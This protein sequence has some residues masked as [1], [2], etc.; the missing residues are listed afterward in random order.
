[1]VH[2]AMALH[3]STQGVF[4][5]PRS[6]KQIRRSTTAYLALV[7]R[8]MPKEVSSSTRTFPCL[9]KERRLLG[10]M[11]CSRSKQHQDVPVK[12]GLCHSV[13]IRGQG[14]MHKVSVL[15]ESQ[16]AI[17]VSAGKVDTS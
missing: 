1:M 5:Q 13:T 8:Q 12:S 7:C 4:E 17:V 9:T 6:R 15:V 11:F 2:L 14:K 10:I 16:Y 3:N